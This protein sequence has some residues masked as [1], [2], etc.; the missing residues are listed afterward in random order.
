MPI[1]DLLRRAIDLNLRYY[2]SVGLLTADYLRDL[3]EV[4]A[5]SSDMRPFAH[6]QSPR[7]SHPQSPRS[8]QS[9]ADPA[10]NARPMMVF[11]AEAGQPA[12]G[13]FMV[14]NHLPHEVGATIAVSKLVDPSGNVLDLPFLFDPA[15]VSLK[16]REQVFVHATVVISEWQKPEVSY[17]GQISIPELGGTSVPIL[18]RRRPPAAAV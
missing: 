5:S 4:V 18:V 14:E 11:D 12:I 16:S 13:V 3:A 15:F 17:S 7:P 2:A 10:A 9:P 1:D 6:T 8:P